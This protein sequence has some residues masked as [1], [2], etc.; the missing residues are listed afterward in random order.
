MECED[1]G[2]LLL[3]ELTRASYK[4][5]AVPRTWEI[6]GELRKRR[7]MHYPHWMGSMSA[8]TCQTS[9]R[10]WDCRRTD[11]TGP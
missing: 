3:L 8:K 4:V 10:R 11:W 5:M 2:E 6:D 1:G 7:S 9:H